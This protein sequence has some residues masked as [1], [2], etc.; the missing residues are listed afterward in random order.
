MQHWH[1]YRKW[2]ERLFHEMCDA[3]QAGRADQNPYDFWYKGEL[4][5]LQNYVIPL[6]TKLRDCVVYGSIGEEYLRYAEL[7]LVEWELKG[8]IIVQ[9]MI[10]QHQVSLSHRRQ[11]ERPGD[12]YMI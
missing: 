10:A 1:L 12:K 5:F 9:E 4:A 8:Q 2:N 7:N 11:P 6:A 3:F